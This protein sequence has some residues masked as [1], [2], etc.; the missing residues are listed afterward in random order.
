MAIMSVS[1]TIAFK[2]FVQFQVKKCQIG[3]KQNQFLQIPRKYCR[4]ETNL[5]AN[6]QATALA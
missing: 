4:E 5:L 3:L 6:A 2:S 1:L